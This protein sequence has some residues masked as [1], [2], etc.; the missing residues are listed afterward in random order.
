M[1]ILPSDELRGKGIARIMKGYIKV[2]WHCIYSLNSQYPLDNPYNTPLNQPQYSPF[3]EFRLWLT[4][5]YKGDLARGRDMLKNERCFLAELAFAE[6]K[7]NQIKCR[8]RA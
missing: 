4:Q 1:G 5:G 3:G 2:F 7:R 6:E 8:F